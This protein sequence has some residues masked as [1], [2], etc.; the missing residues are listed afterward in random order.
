MEPPLLPPTPGWYIIHQVWPGQA[1][2]GGWNYQEIVSRPA[3]LIMP[4]ASNLNILP[5][6][7]FA[8]LAALSQHS[9]YQE[10]LSDENFSSQLNCS[11]RRTSCAGMMSLLELEQNSQAPEVKSWRP[12]DSTWWLWLPPLS[13]HDV[14]IISGDHWH[15]LGHSWMWI[16]LS[17]IYLLDSLVLIKQ[18]ITLLKC[19]DWT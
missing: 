6:E 15:W 2:P 8:D 17:I 16:S 14:F 13:P 4:G 18:K 1:G 3:S 5:P 19:L 11:S 12:S 7:L 10:T 9:N